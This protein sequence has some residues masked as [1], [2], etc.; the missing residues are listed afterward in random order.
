[1]IKI[2][3]IVGT[4][5]QFLKLA[6][7]CR[8]IK[9]F[10]QII[11]V[12]I[13]TG[14]HYD[15]EMSKDLFETLDITKPNYLL[16][17]NNGTH[18]EITGKMMIEIEKIL[19]TENPNFVLVYG[20]CDTTLAGALVAKKLEIKLVHVESGLRSFNKS[21]PEEINRVVTD[22]LSDILLCPTYYAI[23]NLKKVN[24]TNNVYY[25]GNL[26][27][28]LLKMC[29]E[30]Y[31][32]ISILTNNNLTNNYILLTIH[33]HYNTTIEKI[34]QIFYELSHIETKIIFPIHPR[35]KKLI[36][37]NN[38][39]IPNNIKLIN[40]VNYLDMVILQKNCQY[41][42]TDSGGIQPEAWY[43]G[44][45]CIVLRNETEWLDEI[46]NNNNKLFNISTDTNIIKFINDFLSEKSKDYVYDGSASLKIL[47]ILLK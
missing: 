43:L 32:N 45:K 41:I 34:K 1:M 20:D 14:Q 31:H 26:Q 5:P 27:L 30:N 35:T 22:H 18:A 33:R 38:I 21:M 47:E 46:N 25:V 28:E 36:N 16:N 13:H 23:Q 29:L 42:I 11:H 3:S 12:I 15:D 7:L 8:Q 10:P 2:I 39:T 40:P 24:I 6:P 44:K 4:R 19:I 37:D 9:N 17:I